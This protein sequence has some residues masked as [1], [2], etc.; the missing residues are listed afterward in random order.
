[1]YVF[2]ID[3]F[4]SI[5]INWLAI[6]INGIWDKNRYTGIILRICSGK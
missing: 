5:I 4:Y 3:D 6:K 2:T 1:M